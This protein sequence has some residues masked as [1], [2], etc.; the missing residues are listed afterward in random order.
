MIVPTL[1]IVRNAVDSR[2]ATLWNIVQNRQD[3][4]FATHQK[5][6]QGLRSNSADITNPTAGTT[7]TTTASNALA[8]HPTDQNETWLDFLAE[9][10]GL[11]IEMVLTIDVYNGPQGQGYV[12]TVRV[13]HN[14]VFYQR[15]AQVGP[16]TWRAYGWTAV[17]AA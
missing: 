2:L 6:W 7:A 3:A 17:V 12:G 11:P 9:L 15:A 13:G 1:A 4:Y 14:G 16:E 10:N 5:F 8:G